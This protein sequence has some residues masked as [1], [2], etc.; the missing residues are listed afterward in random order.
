MEPGTNHLRTYRYHNPENSRNSMS[1]PPHPL[2]V[3]PEYTT[4]PGD[5]I[6]VQTRVWHS[7][8]FWHN[9]I[10]EY[11]WTKKITRTNVRIYS[12][13][14]TRTNVGINIHR[15][16]FDT[17]E[18]PNK[19]LY[20]KLYEYSNIFEYSSSF[21]TLTHWRTNVRIYLYKQIWYERMSDYIRKRKID[22]N[23]CPNIF[24]QTNFTGMN[25][26]IYF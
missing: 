1:S 2:S 10:S 11:I 18:C 14:F 26:R 13:F 7:W 16:K 5:R 15:N 23:E 3:V 20:W 6:Y 25:G 8:K 21:Y 9:R 22:T 19:Y 4:R 12:F 24:I 17:N